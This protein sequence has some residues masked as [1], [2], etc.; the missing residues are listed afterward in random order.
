MPTI[1]VKRKTYNYNLGTYNNHLSWFDRKNIV[2]VG[3]RQRNYFAVEIIVH[4]FLN[5]SICRPVCHK[6]YV[7][8]VVTMDFSLCFRPNHSQTATHSAAD[9]YKPSRSPISTAA[10]R[11]PYP[12]SPQLQPQP[13]VSTYSIQKLGIH[14]WLTYIN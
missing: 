7:I 3:K 14:L 6:L 13:Q 5:A 9:I 11:Y 2:S 4:K 1:S 12:S 8:I 10:A